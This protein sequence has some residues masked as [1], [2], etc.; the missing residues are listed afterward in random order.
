MAK[1]LYVQAFEHF[2]NNHDD[3]LK[4][5]VA[6]GLFVDAECK[7]AGSQPTWPT[8]SKYKE[9][10]DCGIPHGTSDY[11]EKA[12][13]VLGEFAD[14]IVEQQRATFLEAA[15]KEY[16]TE[17]SAAFEQYKAEAAKS[18]KGFGRGVAEAVAGAAVWTAILIFAAFALKWV[19]PDIYEVLGRVLGKH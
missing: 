15:L 6:F 13:A 18:E 19:Y 10:F 12:T 9:W 5:Y 3:P 4:A 2:Q 7:W 8:N 14:N 1:P 16:K 17:V 11:Y